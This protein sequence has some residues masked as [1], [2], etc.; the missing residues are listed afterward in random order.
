MTIWAIVPVKPL[1]LGK[2]RLADVLSEDER[3]RLNRM[4]LERVLAMLKEVDEIGQVLVVSRDAE[5]LAIARQAGAKT[6]LEDGAQ[7]LN[8]AL[9]RATS[10][11]LGFS[12]RGVLVLPADLPLV[13]PQDIHHFIEDIDEGPLVR[14]APDRRE[15]G[16][17]ALLICPPAT[18]EYDY[19]PGSFKRHC[20]LAGQSGARLEI[21]RIPNLALDLD[22]PSDLDLYRCIVERQECS[23]EEIYS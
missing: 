4:F 16:T 20:E 15:D 12:A 1:R 2:S 13:T 8:L 14:I 21:M 9:K 7:Q 11:A 3:A 23:E 5:A 18:I 10:V 19:G 22:L 6:V 17:N